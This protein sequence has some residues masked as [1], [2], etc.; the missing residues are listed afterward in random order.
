M[1]RVW[2]GA[3][4]ALALCA[5]VITHA[6][7]PSVTAHAAEARTPA[8]PAVER[9]LSEGHAAYNTG[10]YR[11]AVAKGREADAIEPKTAYDIYLIARLIAIASTA[12]GDRATGKQQISRAI[13]TGAML[14]ADMGMMYRTSMLLH[15]HARDYGTAKR[16]GE[17]AA[18]H[19][20]L[21]A[22]QR[23]VLAQ[24]YYF[25][26]DFAAAESYARRALDADRAAGRQP[27]R[28]MLE[29]VA[30]L[31][32]FRGGQQSVQRAPGTTNWPAWAG[33]RPSMPVALGG[34]PLSATELFSEL[35]PS[36]YVVHAA[37]TPGH[38]TSSLVVQGSAVAI[39]NDHLITN[40]HTLEDRPA[41]LL[42]RGTRTGRAELVL[43]DFMADRCILRSV[44]F[45]LTPIRGVRGYSNVT[46]GERVYALGAPMGLELTLTEGIVSARRVMEGE[47]FIQTSTPILG[48]SSGGGLFDSR[49][50]LIG[51]TTWGIRGN[52]SFNF[53]I[54]ADAF[55]K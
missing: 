29:L 4:I 1:H 27:A 6:L 28:E 31:E 14:P 54:P 36:I 18:K 15:F 26:N 48:G 47:D 38:L 44:D 2:A 45:G 55:W 32:Q 50:N 21:E 9:W 17:E 10:D 13:D 39:S 37:P 7:L 33:R 25:T 46:V 49:G 51:I 35:W 30:V 42:K 41:I 11:T 34:R 16:H 5:I 24:S 40:C 19:V 53:A 43:G 22:E 52:E 23:V 12:A 3:F 8:S 20:E